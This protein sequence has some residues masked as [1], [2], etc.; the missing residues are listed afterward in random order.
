MRGLL[1]KELDELIQPGLGG[2][3]P[4]PQLALPLAL[5]GGVVGGPVQNIPQIRQIMPKMWPKCGQ[6]S[7][8]FSQKFRTWDL[9]GLL[10]RHHGEG[11]LAVRSNGPP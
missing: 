6:K 10:L 8:N 9:S 1:T 4:R 5:G 7:L 3:Q 11:L 2:L